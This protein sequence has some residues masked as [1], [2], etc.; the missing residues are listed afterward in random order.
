MQH[1]VFYCSIVQPKIRELCTVP[2]GS[3][4][5]HKYFHDM[6]CR[7]LNLVSHNMPIISVYLHCFSQFI[8]LFQIM[9]KCVQKHQTLVFIHSAVVCSRVVPK[10]MSQMR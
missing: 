6:V 5:A 7:F 8:Y 9:Y 10:V 1:I 4:S 2:F 3:F